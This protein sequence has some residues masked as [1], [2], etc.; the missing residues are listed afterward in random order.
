MASDLFAELVT[1]NGIRYQQPLGLF[2]DNK[3]VPSKSDSRISTIDPAT[4][5]VITK[6][7]AA[8]AENVNDAV[9]AA[10]RAFEGPWGDKTGA[11]RG[12]L[13]NT[14]ADVVERNGKILAAI[15]SWDNGKP[16]SS[17]I[18]EDIPE[19]LDVLRYYAGWADKN[20]G[21]VI[22]TRGT[23]L[24][25]TVPEPIGV[26]AQII[27]WNY[28]IVMLSWKLAPAIAAGNCI[29]L[30][31]SE[32]TPLSAL[33]LARLVEAA[34]F[35][36]GVINIINGY[37]PEAGSALAAHIDVDKVAFTGSTQ[38]G[39][40]IMKL[41]SSNLKSVTLETG[42]KS[43]LV[44]FSDANLHAAAATGYQGIMGNAGQNCSANSKILVQEDIFDRFLKLFK[45]RAI[46][47]SKIGSPFENETIQGPQITKGQFDR[48]LSYVQ[49][50]R[51][52]G[53]TLV[54]GGTAYKDLNGKGFYIEPTIFTDVTPQMRI[55]KEEIFGPFV[56][57][58]AFK[59]ETEAVRLANDTEYG[60]AA[61]VFTK[62]ITR[63]LRLTRKINAGTVWIN[64]SQI[65]DP[66]VPFGGFKQS[67]IGREQG[68]AGFK[69]YTKYKTV[70]V[71]LAL[72]P[73]NAHTEAKL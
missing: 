53:A 31:V 30:K 2:I 46:S 59:T 48:I 72:D 47:E 24:N 8:S 22:E 25:Y 35:P 16:Y 42:G 60:L 62:D 43:P 49:S 54:H 15:E 68:E 28:P 37:G 52:E 5:K 26:C 13:L 19:F 36:P 55:Y 3:F 18:S 17:S 6:V 58:L 65:M 44:V 11:E 10:R 45:A 9:L 4:E 50:G 34:G 40:E 1:P 33:Y 57:I 7:H 29:I 39:R 64:N 56:V 38:T 21:Q 20:H 61:A 51:D 73:V 69:A 23:Q 71:D 67:G 27:P 14:F 63:A 12:R 32:Q 41:A 66:R 70:I